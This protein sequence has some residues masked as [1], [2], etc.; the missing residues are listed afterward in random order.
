MRLANGRMLAGVTTAALA[1]MGSIHPVSVQA[2][3]LAMRVKVPFEF[4]VGRARL[5]AGTYMVQRVGDALRIDD[6]K[7]HAAAVISNAIDN[8]AVKV[9]NQIVFNR[10]SNDYF[11]SEAR[12]V[13]YPSSRGLPK[14]KLEKE[15]AQTTSPQQILAAALT[16]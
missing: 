4:H 1:L 6:G 7:G 15:L 13:G 8:R 5:P 10:Y 11:L 12:W 3:S 9:D 16:R 2:Q 14:S